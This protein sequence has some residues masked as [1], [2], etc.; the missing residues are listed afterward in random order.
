MNWFDF[1]NF[2][3]SAHNEKR[4]EDAQPCLSNVY[5]MSTRAKRRPTDVPLCGRS[6]VEMLGVLAIIG[7]L[8]VGAMTGYSKAMFKYK[9]NKQAE[10]LYLFLNNAIMLTPELNRS[11][12]GTHIDKSLFIKL[13]LVPDGM[14]VENNNI[15]D[16]FNNS[17]YPYYY[18]PTNASA[19]YNEYYISF[20]VN[21]FENKL[22]E[23]YREICRNI[24][25]VAKEY[26]ADISS[27]Q[28]R[29][30]QDEGNSYTRV[31]LYGDY[32]CSRGSTNCLSNA[33]LA[34][35]DNF[36]NSCNSEDYCQFY[37][38]IKA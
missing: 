19:D 28:M 24:V 30:G 20:T 38:F 35:M 36:C 3:S 2:F 33:G 21:R 10:S 4:P 5:K 13:N 22:T 25:T 34:E 31:S 1:F 9:L 8:S 37:I 26:S 17:V 7:V 23:S 14:T 29:S 15:Y 32:Y 11:F 12:D 6:M 16:V 27:V 18:H